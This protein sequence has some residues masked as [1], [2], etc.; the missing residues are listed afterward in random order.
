MEME[1][2]ICFSERS[3]DM[4]ALYIVVTKVALG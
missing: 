3:T 1:N 4:I 2:I